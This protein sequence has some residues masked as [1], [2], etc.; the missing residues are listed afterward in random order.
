M[1]KTLLSAAGD[2][3][4]AQYGSPPPPSPSGDEPRKG[5]GFRGFL[6]RIVVSMA[7]AVA[8]YW[9]TDFWAL[10][11]WNS[12]ESLVIQVLSAG[13]E[14]QVPTEGGDQESFPMLRRQIG[15]R[16]L[17]GDQRDMTAEI[18]VV[19][20]EGSG[21][22][23]IPG[24]RYLLVEDV[25]EDGEVQYSIA[26]AFRIPSIIAFVAAV[27][28]FLLAL[29]NRSGFRALL[30]LAISLVVLIKGMIPLMVKGWHPMGLAFLAILLVSAGTIFCVVRRSCY[31]CAALLGSLSG[32]GFGFLLGGLMVWEWQLSGLAGEG[33]ALLASTLPEMNMRGVLL[34]SILV[35]AIGAVL[36]VAV[37]VTASMAELASYAPDIPLR[38]LW[39]AGINVGSEVLGSMIN[40]LVLAYLGSS[41]PTALL[42][43]SAGA[44][45]LGI[46][47]DPY[48]GQQ[49]VQS[50]A[51]TVGL[52]CTIPATAF[53]FVVQ[54]AWNRHHLAPHQDAPAGEVAE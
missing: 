17:T 4:E 39:L 22:D 48:I 27:C 26:D 49:I 36:D 10:R 40:T 45:L 21:L 28:L 1:E 46:L 12:Q 2:T 5:P 13:P 15:I 30:G 37:S 43:S 31:R 47:N 44:D 9:G 34:A 16:I 6:L 23:P 18:P 14:S 19:R 25:F 35:S 38:R 24:R 33:A 11:V 50:L 3:H 51:G 7:A 29:A 8:V 53:F 42:I 32:T 20:L 41:L 52:L 54:E